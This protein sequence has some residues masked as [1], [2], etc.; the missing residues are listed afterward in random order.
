MK[1][2]WMIPVVAASPL[3]V[4]LLAVSPLGCI[5]TTSRPAPPTASSEPSSAHGAS[6][7]PLASA[8][9]PGTTGAAAAS[10]S[11]LASAHAD[12]G[13]PPEY[14]ELTP[15]PCPTTQPAA[16]AP[17]AKITLVD[18]GAEPRKALRYHPKAGLRRTVSYQLESHAR[19]EQNGQASE[20]QSVLF[21]LTVDGVI[22]Q[23]DDKES[24]YEF[25]VTKVDVPDA[26]DRAAEYTA[27]VRK[28][29]GKWVDLRGAMVID[30][31]GMT[32]KFEIANPPSGK[33]LAAM[34]DIRVALEQTA[35]PLPEEP[36]GVG[37][38]WDVSTVVDT[39]LVLRGKTTFELLK[40]KADSGT[41]RFTI[42]QRSEKV[43][44][45]VCPKPNLVVVPLE[46]IASGSGERSFSLKELLAGNFDTKL[47]VHNATRTFVTGQGEAKRIDGKLDVDIVTRMWVGKK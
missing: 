19:S 16:Q 43:G 46:W 6:A 37:A 9:A 4:G 25:H 45:A 36:V 10:G 1:R 22:A 2:L 12:A 41:V 30:S 23:A 13:T 33:S 21:T 28:E 20:Q 35:N 17:E 27:Q 47:K 34:Q 39:G 15:P 40:L 42:E 18:P 3:V 31:R 38:K 44:Q 24:R 32:Q 29:L 26:K 11:A 5:F 7:E 8:G 14:S